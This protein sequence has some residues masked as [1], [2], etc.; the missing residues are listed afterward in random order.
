MTRVSLAGMNVMDIGQLWS[1]YERERFKEMFPDYDRELDDD[2]GTEFID[3]T[4]SDTP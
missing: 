4:V 2:D 1:Y 3:V